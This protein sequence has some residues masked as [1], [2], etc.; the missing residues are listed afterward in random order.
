MVAEMAISAVVVLTTA[1]L[2]DLLV[3]NPG[4]VTERFAVKRY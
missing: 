3:R 2:V 1:A 4:Q